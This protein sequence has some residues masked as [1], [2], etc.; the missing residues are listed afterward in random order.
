MTLYD[1]KE[2]AAHNHKDSLWVVH[3]GS[4]YD[5]TE[6]SEIHPGGREYLLEYAGGVEDVQEVIKDKNVHIHSK[7]AY[8]ILKRNYIGKMKTAVIND[9]NQNATTVGNG[10][11]PN[12]VVS[13]GNGVAHHDTDSDEEEDLTSM[14]GYKEEELIDWKKPIYWQVGTLGEQYKDW[15]HNPVDKPLRLFYSDFCEFFSMAP[16]QLIPSLWIPIAIIFIYMS[17]C[18]FL[19]AGQVDFL[20]MKLGLS[21][22]PIIFLSG[23]L[24]WT[25]F[26]YTIHRWIF[27]NNPPSWSPFLIRMHFIMHGQHHK[28]PFER[29]RLVFPPVPASIFAVSIYAIYMLSLPKPVAEA[30]SAEVNIIDVQV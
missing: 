1:P 28:C 21:S 23:P 25:L 7:A 20:G 12:G 14:Q 4:I 6:F 30:I 11:G 3:K 19:T 22:L 8:N 24:F 17:Y 13:N 2:V 27:H 10:K 16:W 26:E 9:K 5:V 18:S 29:F 15:V